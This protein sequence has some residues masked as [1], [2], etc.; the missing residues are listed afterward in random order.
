M[1]AH[2][3]ARKHASIVNVRWFFVA[4]GL[5][6]SACGS[7]D[8][9]TDITC[10][11]AILYLDRGGGVFEPGGHDDAI[12]NT[13]VLVDVERTLPAWPHADWAD[14]A[15]C[16]HD[17]LLALPRLTVTDVDPGMTPHTTIVFTTAYWAGS[18]ATTMI[19]PASCRP[20]HEI[21][22][23]FGD[24]IPTTARACHLALQGFAQMSANLSLGD[25]CHDLVNN[26]MDCS[27]DRSFLDQTVN[28]VDDAGAPA[29]CRCGGTTE[30]TYQALTTAFPPCP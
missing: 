17:H 6:A 10:R 13:S 14:L 18:T 26:S 12:T 24:A 8:G 9:P 16:I 15:A 3:R 11:Q 25:D 28:C 20:D 7:D 5:A 27:I 22:F 30:N 1:E 4:F 21:E 23:V 19:V 2:A 29:P